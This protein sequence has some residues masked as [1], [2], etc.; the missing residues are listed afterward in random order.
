MKRFL[1]ILMAILMSLSLIACD[2]EETPSSTGSSV[3]D[4]TQNSGTTDSSKPGTQGGSTTDS[5][6]PEDVN[7]DP[8]D[9]NPDNENPGG[10]TGGEDGNTT[11]LVL[12]QAVMKQLEAASTLKLEFSLEAVLDSDEWY[13]DGW[14]KNEKTYFEGVADFTAYISKTENGYNLKL[15][16]DVRSKDTENGDFLPDL[17]GGVL[18]IVDGVVYEYNEALDVYLVSNAPAIDTSELEGILNALIE[19]AGLSEEEINGILNELGNLLIDGFGIANNRGSSYVD[20]KPEFDKALE[21]FKELDLETKTLREFINDM[22]ASVDEELTVESLLTDIEAVY[23][24]TLGEYLAALDEELVAAYGMTLDEMYTEFVS[25]ETVQM[26]IAEFMLAVTPEAT[27][28]DIQAIIDMLLESQLSDLIPEE[29]MN[30]KIYDIIIMMLT[31]QE[32]D[33]DDGV[34]LISSTD[35]EYPTVEEIMATIDMYL[36][37]TLADFESEMGTPFEILVELAKSITIDKLDTSLDIEFTGVFKIKTVT[38]QTN[39]GVTVTTPSEVSGKNDVSSISVTLTFALV[40]ISKDEYPIYAPTDKDEIANVFEKEFFSDDDLVLSVVI[41]EDGSIYLVAYQFVQGSGMVEAIIAVPTVDSF[42]GYEIEL[43]TEQIYYFFD[44]E[45]PLSLTF[46]LYPEMEYFEME[47]EMCE[48]LWGSWYEDEELPGYAYRQCAVCGGYDYMELAVY[49]TITYHNMDG[50]ENPNPQEYMSDDEVFSLLS[51][52]KDGYLFEGWYLDEELTIEIIEVDPSIMGDFEVYA[53]W[54]QVE[55]TS[56]P[57]NEPDATTKWNGQTLN[58]LATTW[59]SQYQGAPWSQV[60]L[61]VHYGN[62]SDM[63][64]S[65]VINSSVIERE[66]YIKKQYGV[67]INWINARSNQLIDLLSDSMASGGATYHIAM[68]RMLEAQRLV[69]ENVLCD[70]SKSEYINLDASYYSQAAR[71]AYTVKGVTL[72]AAG[73]FSFLDEQTSGVLYYNQAM[74]DEI[75]N[76]PDLYQMVRE[77]KWTIDEM[78]NVAKLVTN[79]T[80]TQM[81]DDG[82][83]GF[84]TT[85]LS[86]FYQYSGIKQVSV[87]GGEY[88]LSLND[89]KVNTLIDKLLTINNAAWARLT[90]NGGFSAMEE[91]FEDGRLLFYNEVVQKLDA[92]GGFTSDFKPAILPMPKLDTDQAGYYTPASYQAV[93]MCIPKST[94]D[95][96][97]SEFFFE[98]LSYTGQEYIMRAYN[99][100]LL[101]KLYYGNAYES[102]E[103]LEEYIFPGIIYDVGYMHSWNGLMTSVQNDSYKDG[104]NNFGFAY[105]QASVN[106]LKTIMDWNAA[107]SNHGGQSVTITY[108]TGTGYFEYDN[109][110]EKTVNKDSRF[111]NHPTPLHTNSS[112][113]FNGW[114][115]DPECETAVS[116]TYKYSE[117]TILYAGWS[118]SS[119][120][121][122]GGGHTFTAWNTKDEPTCIENGTFARTCSSCGYTEITDGED[123]YGHNWSAWEESFM[124]SERHCIRGC[125]EKQ[126]KE[127][128]NVT[129]SVVSDFIISGDY[130]GTG[131]EEF[132]FDGV[133]DQPY[134]QAVAPKGTGLVNVIISLEKTSVIDRIYVK[135]SGFGSAFYVKVLYVDESESVLVGTGDFLTQEENES[136]DRQIPCFEVDSTKAINSVMVIINE[137]SNGL[138][139]LEEIAFV[140]I[141]E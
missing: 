119:E 38:A 85:D 12:T 26:L 11:G 14:A 90:W 117:D 134:N 51:P 34:I 59:N 88:V 131:K 91:A 45:I 92:F 62:Y 53:K 136:N 83:Y 121:T 74:A 100:T 82:T 80:G 49:Y 68:P 41:E 35:V 112:Y 132:L 13:V 58:V 113:V 46:T 7:K 104:W 102:K 39:F 69:S 2:D 5:S 94:E 108:D 4:S 124:K 137:P 106:A 86:K 42:D 22:L 16:A 110:Y 129:Y 27:E 66:A 57:G 3:T 50:V 63:N 105:N 43:T 60:E 133:W 31:S 9:E 95:R 75:E 77:G 18:Y 128:E 123:A 98:V 130:Y 120:C 139:Y 141:P 28:E 19:E 71:E 84:G 93:V 65:T 20:F 56:N 64:F 101:S 70:L 37:M 54:T 15:E 29:M 33:G 10:N 72:F 32:E 115:I 24:M 87:S 21:Y 1:L 126:T 67:E 109:M 81:G 107:W 97:M 122:G 116:N 30:V 47:Y 89:T 6:S 96:E 40:E 48:H 23:N 8:S 99:Q 79:G 55:D 127:Y 135:G 103:M 61:V 118:V 36:E 76:F 25:N 44:S 114:Y 78:V 52:T 111:A 140:C 73:D 125:G 138:D 17:N